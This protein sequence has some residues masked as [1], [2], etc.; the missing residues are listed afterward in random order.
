MSSLF[1][2]LLGSLFWDEEKILMILEA[3]LQG[4]LRFWPGCYDQKDLLLSASGVP[5]TQSVCQ[6]TGNDMYLASGCAAMQDGL[7]DILQATRQAPTQVAT[8]LVAGCQ[9]LRCRYVPY[10]TIFQT[11]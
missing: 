11:G 6:L 4:L 2:I 3:A 9:P 1:P 8:K 7:L 10:M 5:T